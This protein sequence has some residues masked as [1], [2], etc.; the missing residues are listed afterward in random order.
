MSEKAFDALRFVSSEEVPA[1]DWHRR[2]QSRDRAARQAYRSM[3][4]QGEY[5][6]NA[7]YI[8]EIMREGL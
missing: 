3:V 7:R 8:A 6:E 1:D 5:D 4:E 2:R